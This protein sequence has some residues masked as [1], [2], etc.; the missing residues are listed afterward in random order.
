M[1]ES[2]KVKK[3]SVCDWSISLSESSRDYEELWEELSESVGDAGG[4]G[5]GGIGRRS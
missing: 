3:S 5:G 4:G 2:L 1:R